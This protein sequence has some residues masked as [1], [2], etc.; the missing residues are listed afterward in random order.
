MDSEE[1]DIAYSVGIGAI[2][3]SRHIQIESSQYRMSS[4]ET[5]EDVVFVRSEFVAKSNAKDRDSAP[6]LPETL[7]VEGRVFYL[8]NAGHASSICVGFV[9]PHEE[10]MGMHRFGNEHILVRGQSA[11]ALLLPALPFSAF[12][13]GSLKCLRDALYGEVYLGSELKRWDQEWTH[14]RSVVVKRVSLNLPTD[15]RTPANT[16][17]LRAV[18]PLQDTAL[19]NA[20]VEIELTKCIHDLISTSNAAT[21]TTSRDRKRKRSAVGAAVRIAEDR[22]VRHFLVGVF[23]DSLFIMA[24]FAPL[25]SVECYMHRCGSL[26]QELSERAARHVLRQM[27]QNL[28]FLHRH[29]IAHRDGSLGNLVLV[30]PAA[31]AP[32]AVLSDDE[33]EQLTVQNIDLA[34]GLQFAPPPAAPPLVEFDNAKRPGKRTCRPPE[35]LHGALNASGPRNYDPTKLDVFHAGVAGVYMFVGFTNYTM[36]RVSGTN[37]PSVASEEPLLWRDALHVEKGL[38]DNLVYQWVREDGVDAK[39]VVLKSLKKVIPTQALHL[40]QQLLAADPEQRPSA[41]QALQHPW[42]RS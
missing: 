36:T 8:Y 29:G 24:P 33:F 42:F 22:F 30:G 25:G 37:G 39:R 7:L 5:T 34:Q 2:L 4:N 32:N 41:E 11:P 27:L 15:A 28:A 26:N 3:K 10:L 40:L 21:S 19:E 35:L 9:F 13:G 1:A 23:S 18:L 17:D 14:H 31:F 6:V 38:G 16:A 12:R 20:A